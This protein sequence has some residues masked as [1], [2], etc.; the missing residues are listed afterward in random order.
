MNW[1]YQIVRV[2]TA[3][4]F[5][6]ALNKLGAEGWEAVSGAY[7]LSESRKVTLGHG[8]APSMAPGIPTWIALMKRPLKD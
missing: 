4:A 3:E 5:Q 8:M 2:E 7:A 6:L 1:E